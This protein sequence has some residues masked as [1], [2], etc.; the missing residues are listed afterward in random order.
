[1]PGVIKP[2]T[3]KCKKNSNSRFIF[4]MVIMFYEPYEHVVSGGS[5]HSAKQLY[6]K[7]RLPVKFSLQAVFF[8]A[9]YGSC[10]RMNDIT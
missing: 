7:R 9:L 6:L 2:I 8:L 1:M 3:V 4:P 10:R 5:V